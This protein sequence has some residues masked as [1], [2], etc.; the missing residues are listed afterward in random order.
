MTI[1]IQVSDIKNTTSQSQIIKDLG[2]QIEDAKFMALN[3]EKIILSGDCAN[4]T[5]TV[6]EEGK[7]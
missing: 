2:F 7:K 1:T 4:Y 3:E 5:I 6:I